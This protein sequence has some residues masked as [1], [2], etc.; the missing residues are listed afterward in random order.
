MFLAEAGIIMAAD[1]EDM[2][3]GVDAGCS[4]GSTYWWVPVGP[5]WGLVGRVM[6]NDVKVHRLFLMKH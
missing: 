5:C 4:R 3:Q 1:R 6:Y 2:Y